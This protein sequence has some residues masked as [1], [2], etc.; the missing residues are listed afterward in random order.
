MQEYERERFIALLSSQRTSSGDVIFVL[1]GD[2]IFRAARAVELFK[3][4][5]APAVSI[6]GAAD[7]PAYG[8]LPSELVRDEMLRLGLPRRALFFEKSA[9]HTRAEAECAFRLAIE[10]GWK[11]I[12]I[13]TSPHH[14]YRAFLTFLKAMNDAGLDLELVN[15]PA[16]LSWTEQTPW[17]RRVDLLAQEFDRITKYQGKGDVASYKEGAAYLMRT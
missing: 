2:G 5:A 7:N 12:I 10:L 16:R 17:G 14:Q 9:A 13:V 3:S 15:A 4:G 8:S 11:N 1:Q 6:V